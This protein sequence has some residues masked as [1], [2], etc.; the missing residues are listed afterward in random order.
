MI[1]SPSLPFLSNTFW[2]TP[3]AT[4][5]MLIAARVALA[6]SLLSAMLFAC[7]VL[8]FRRPG[9][10]WNKRLL[11]PVSVLI[12]ARNEEASIE[13][14]VRSVLSSRGVNLELIVLDDGST[15]ST[16]E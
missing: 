7:N 13:A 14:A 10:D 11:P 15:D 3:V 8:L 1:L 9:P 16:A 12:P 2:S 6:S 5:W 4:A